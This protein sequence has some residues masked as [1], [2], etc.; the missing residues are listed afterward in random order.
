MSTYERCVDEGKSKRTVAQPRCVGN[1]DIANQVDGIVADPVQSVARRV[2][3]CAVECGVDDDPNNI[4]SQEP[5]F[6][7]SPDVECLCNGKLEH[8][9]N[10]R[11]ENTGGADG[12]QSVLIAETDLSGLE[13]DRAL[14]RQH[15]NNEPNPV[16][17]LECVADNE[18]TTG[19]Y[20][21]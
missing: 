20:Q 3:S 13:L 6:S 1:E 16:H 4:D 14:K 7:T 21:A 19:S 11:T 17:V 12:R 15:E 2:A 10:D 9:A 18:T 8:A 5:R